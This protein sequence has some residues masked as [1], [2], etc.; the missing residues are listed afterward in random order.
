M[1]FAENPPKQYVPWKPNEDFIKFFEDMKKR[2]ITSKGNEESIKVTDTPVAANPVKR[3]GNG[4]PKSIKVNYS[5][6]SERLV[7]TAAA[8][9]K[10][11]RA[12]KKSPPGKRTARRA[13]TTKGYT[14]L[15]RKIEN[16]KF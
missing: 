16:H 5:S 8:Q 7:N 3:N 14:S 2:R 15:E 6:V 10:W 4:K 12:N 1:S 11:N 9:S 13:K